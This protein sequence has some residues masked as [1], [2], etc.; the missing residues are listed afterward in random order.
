MEWVFC[1]PKSQSISV[2]AAITMHRGGKVD[3]RIERMTTT[4]ACHQSALLQLEEVGWSS[5]WGCGQG[6][7]RSGWRGEGMGLELRVLWGVSGEGRGH[8]CGQ[9]CCQYPMPPCL[10]SPH[11]LEYIWTGTKEL[12]QF[13]IGFMS[14][15]SRWIRIFMY[16]TFHQARIPS[17]PQDATALHRLA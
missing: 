7:R 10:A 15:Q 8:H 2:V 12:K 6:E 1:Q 4:C 17:Q 16:L 14:Q 11:L 9:W 13:W 5:R 3:T